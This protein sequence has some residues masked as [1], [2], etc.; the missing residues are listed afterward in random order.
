MNIITL[1]GQRSMGGKPD[2][3]QPILINPTSFIAAFTNDD[4]CMVYL[5]G[6][7]K[8]QVVETQEAIESMLAACD[9]PVVSES[10]FV[11]E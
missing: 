3:S 8:L 2:P 5:D 11:S 10:E 4:G 6:G 1:N 9:E 7:L